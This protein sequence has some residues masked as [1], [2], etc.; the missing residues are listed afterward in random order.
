MKDNRLPKSGL[1][2][3]NPDQQK[4]ARSVYYEGGV[5][6]PLSDSAAPLET[7]LVG[8]AFCLYKFFHENGYAISRS[9]WESKR[10]NAALRSY[11]GWV[12]AFY[13]EGEF[14]IYVG[15]TG[16][17]L[18][19]RFAEHT[20]SQDWRS[21]WM[22]AKVLPCPNQAMRKIFESLIGLAGGYHGNKAQ[23]TGADNILDDILLSLLYLGN[24]NERSPIF[25][26]ESISTHLDD[27]RARIDALL[28]N[29]PST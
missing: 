29:K 10:T 23:P 15:E 26:N 8:S 12:Y 5:L 13:G 25:P 1:Q 27:V 18:A 20:R 19:R 7:V 17:S 28:S 9:E 4:E 6:V 11:V 16:R 14:P 2:S 24:D 3:R 22:W 21:D